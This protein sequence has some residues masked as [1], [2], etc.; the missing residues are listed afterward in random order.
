M[1]FHGGHSNYRETL[2]H[3]GFP[4]DRFQLITPS[5][6]GYEDTPLNELKTPSDAAD[7]FAALLDELGMERCILVGISAGGLAALAF[8]ARFPERVEKLL[9]ISAV[10][11]RWML[12]DHPN[13]QRGRKLFAPRME[14]ISWFLFRT[15][16]RLLPRTMTRVLFDQLSTRKNARITP[17]EVE[18]VKGMTFQQSSGDGFVNDLEQT[19]AEKYLA[20]ISCPTL[21]LHSENDAS[22]SIDMATHA[23]KHIPQ[24]I[25]K[26]Y[27]NKWGHLLWVGD[28]S[29]A[30]I[31]DVL[32]FLD[33]A[34]ENATFTA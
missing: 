21:I 27:D 6:P 11:Q 30:P 13:Y 32:T 4:L 24:S 25:L 34:D 8:A 26:T 5:R 2:F 22:V 7:L 16:F 23:H 29:Q 15:G 10:T 14:K 17:E 33:A 19:L 28:D 12:P 31:A 1:F 20:A 9:L 18:A 3:R